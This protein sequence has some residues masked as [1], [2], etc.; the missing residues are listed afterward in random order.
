MNYLVNGFSP[1][2]QRYGNMT[3]IQEALSESEFID[4]LNHGKFKSYIGHG[5][6]ARHLT[7]ITG[8]TITENRKEVKA[9]YDDL[10]LIVSVAGRLPKS[11]KNIHYNG[12]L[13][14]KLLRFEKPTL[15]DLLKTKRIINDII[16]EA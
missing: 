8:K 11:N 10:I 13:E 3:I 2:M 5:K 9:G 6:L 16:M 14:F 7:S 12:N 4:L 15:E 1:K